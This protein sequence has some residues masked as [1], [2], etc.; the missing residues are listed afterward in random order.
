MFNFYILGYKSND[1]KPLFCQGHHIGLVSRDVEVE[2]LPYNDIFVIHPTK[3]DLCPGIISYEE[4]SAQVA[5]VLSALRE[6]N[7]FTA[8]KGWRNETFEIKPSY[9][10]PALF[11]MERAATCMF[12]LR[13]YGCDVNGYVV[14]EDGS[15]SVWMQRRSLNK[16]TWPGK[17]DNF[18][19]GGLS[20]G[21][22]IRETV[23]KE[24][25]EEAS[26]PRH[27]AERMEPAGCVR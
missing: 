8:L 15:L 13:Q 6:K 9:G 7:K 5:R 14:N 10:Q 21:Y 24:T 23:I 1:Y 26:L 19:A 3:I 16:P 17:L 20:S 4:I 27:I 11:A 12:G 25:E 18:V 22:S 2:L